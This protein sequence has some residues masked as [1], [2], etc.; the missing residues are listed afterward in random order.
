LAIINEK[1][2]G[3][4]ETKNPEWEHLGRRE[5]IKGEKAGV[6]G[7]GFVYCS[8]N[9]PRLRR[10]KSSPPTP[11]LSSPIDGV[12]QK[13]RGPSVDILKRSNARAAREKGQQIQ[14]KT[15]LKKKKRKK[16]HKKGKD[17]ENREE[18]IT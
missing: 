3:K 9:L 18:F 17:E 1:G 2:K 5:R 6:L 15:N 12:L 14:K 8:G 16:T 11:N 13:F 10:G 4:R 7:G